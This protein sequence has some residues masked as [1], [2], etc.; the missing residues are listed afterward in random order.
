VHATGERGSDGRRLPKQR[1]SKRGK[2]G[3]D[4]AKDRE[5]LFREFLKDQPKAKTEPANE[6][7]AAA[8][9]PPANDT[10]NANA[11]NANTT[12]ANTTKLDPGNDTARP[13]DE[14]ASQSAKVEPAKE[15]DTP[16]LRLDSGLPATAPAPS[17]AGQEPSLTGRGGAGSSSDATS[18]SSAAGSQPAFATSASPPPAAPAGP[19]TPPMSQ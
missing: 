9:E 2:P 18:T 14:G 10:A 17:D 13:A 16:A 1:L 6:E 8:A 7:P 5:L 12:N 15:V 11:A 19:P 4:A 3:D